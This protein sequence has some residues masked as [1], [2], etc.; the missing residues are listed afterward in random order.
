MSQEIH[1][2]LGEDM[3]LRDSIKTSLRSLLNR[4]D[5]PV[6]GQVTEVSGGWNL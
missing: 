3:G 1:L 5:D 6:T 4:L 2:R